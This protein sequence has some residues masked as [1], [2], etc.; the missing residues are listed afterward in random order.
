[1][2]GRGDSTVCSLEGVGASWL[3]CLENPEEAAADGYAID[4]VQRMFMKLA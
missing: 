1:V 3:H 2:P 4:E